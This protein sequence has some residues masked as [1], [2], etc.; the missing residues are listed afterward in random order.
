MIYIDETKMS[1]EMEETQLSIIQMV[2]DPFNP[3]H[4]HL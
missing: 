2:K 4:L 3:S 1:F